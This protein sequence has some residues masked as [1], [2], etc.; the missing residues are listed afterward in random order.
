MA[1]RLARHRVALAVGT[2]LAVV[3]LVAAT[4]ILPWLTRDREVVSSTPVR[5]ELLAPQE[6]ALQPGQRACVARVPFDP[7]GRV[8]RVTIARAGAGPARLSLAASGGAYRAQASARVPA[9]YE[10]ALDIPFAP[11][12][13][14]LIGTLCVGNAGGRAIAL[15]GTVHPWAIVRPQMTLD[16]QPVA[17]AF[18][19]TLL[20]PGRRSYLAR[21][22]QLV[23]RAAALSAV[24]PW[25]FWLL[26][27]LLVVGVPAGVTA[28]LTLAL[29]APTPSTA[30]DAGR[31]RA[32][33]G[34]VAGPRSDGT[35]RA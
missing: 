7:D 34:S 17:E 27:A 11:P 10:G 25:L 5:T 29:R 19:L 16:G 26:L 6:I 30:A 15:A 3:A 35:A 4:Q 33:P 2:L 23:E 31:P 14:D 18:T 24:G 1:D 28:A 20:E 21:V 32:R 12:T 22:P 8:A 9:D 13:R